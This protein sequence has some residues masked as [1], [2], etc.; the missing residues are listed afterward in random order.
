MVD[1]A[2][3]VAILL[4]AGIYRGEFGQVECSMPILVSL[5]QEFAIHH[6]QALRGIIVSQLRLVVVHVV[7]DGL[8]GCFQGDIPVIAPDANRNATFI[9]GPEA[10]LNP[11]YLPNKLV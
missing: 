3:D 7:V 2:F 1:I 9:R 11:V 10:T 6:I 4:D 8:N 5:Y